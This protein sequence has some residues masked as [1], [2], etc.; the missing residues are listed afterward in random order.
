M[1]VSKGSVDFAFCWSYHNPKPSAIAH[2]IALM[3]LN[4]INTVAI[5][6][7]TVKSLGVIVS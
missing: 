3:F 2:L 5:N 4:I 6:I 1:S 7:Y